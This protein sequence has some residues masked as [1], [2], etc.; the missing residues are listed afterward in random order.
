MKLPRRRQFLHLAAGA[1]ALRAVSRFVWTNSRKQLSVISIVFSMMPVCGEAATL[2][3][4]CDAGEKI[5]Q[6][7]AVAKPGD[8][9]KVSG[10]CNESVQI[11][12]EIVRIMLDGQGKATIQ[13]ASA[14]GFPI[15]IRARKSR[16]KASHSRAVAMEFIYLEPPP[17]LRRLLKTISFAK[18]GVESIWMLAALPKSPTIGSRTLEPRA[19]M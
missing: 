5:Q 10:T 3:V 14:T 4:N 1:A 9:I 17:G 13:A 18:R 11:F 12:S 19:S 7:L 2:T 16:S 15:Y 8:E 6:K